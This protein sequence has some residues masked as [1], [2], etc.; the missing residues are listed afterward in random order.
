MPPH[1][2]VYRANFQ[3]FAKPA[4]LRRT[5]PQ[6]KKFVIFFGFATKNLNG[7]RE[8]KFFLRLFFQFAFT[9]KTNAPNANFHAY[10]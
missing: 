6:K 4:F 8:I 7:G 9:N 1:L 5:P 10:K 2:W 3:N